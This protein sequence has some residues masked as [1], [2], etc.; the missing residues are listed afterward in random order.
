MVAV[1]MLS[2]MKYD[3]K[4]E[5]LQVSSETL[6]KTCSNQQISGLS[7]IFLLMLTS[8]GGSFYPN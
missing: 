8:N 4:F 7:I 2:M 3:Q 6:F 5:K 1:E